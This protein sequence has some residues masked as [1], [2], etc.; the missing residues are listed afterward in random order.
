MAKPSACVF[1]AVPNAASVRAAT[2]QAIAKLVQE[3]ML[4]RATVRYLTAAPVELARHRLVREFLADSSFTHILFLDSDMSPQ[5][6]TLDRLLRLKA[7][8]AC[9]PCPILAPAL[10]AEGVSGPSITTNI[11]QLASPPNADARNQVV[12]YLDPDEFPKTPFECHGTGLACCLIQ[13]EVF[14]R[15]T[16][17]YFA[18]V[19]GDEYS[20]L[21]IGEDAFFFNKARE[22]EYRIKVDPMLL[23]DHFKE[24]DV[25]HLE[26]FF[27]DETIRWRWNEGQKP[28]RDES[29]FIAALP[30]WMDCH[31]ELARYL[32]KESQKPNQAIDVF[33]CPS[34]S[35]GLED[36]LEH[37]LGERTERYLFLLD[38]RTV[39][40]DD[41][42][43]RF[44][45][46]PARL[47]SGL[48][49]EPGPAGPIWGIWV[50]D[51]RVTMTCDSDDDPKL[52][53]TLG[54]SRPQV[55][56]RAVY[57]GTATPKDVL[58]ASL[59]ATIIDRDLLSKLGTDWARDAVSPERAGVNLARAA[60]QKAGTALEV[61]PIGCRH[62]EPGPLGIF[63]R[64]KGELK[65]QARQRNR[66]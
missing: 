8:I 20:S 11:W 55:L 29:V 36:A 59:R 4:A 7:P 2:I 18:M 33:R 25:T 43:E 27:R 64:I 40:P 17:P 50:P 15:M 47:A 35:A 21:R 42:L 39:P 23:C 12:R 38:D 28:K 51:V 62:F 10:A 19:F 37:F 57:D 30:A 48:F 44:L 60:R 5:P 22:L 24:I 14:E 46:S 16:P 1:I 49:R 3:T 13:R 65:Q 61:I 9:A 66:A 26:E 52:A 31:A 41:F 56:E 63:L 58:A 32:T 54:L 6:Q 53:E 34:F 45:A